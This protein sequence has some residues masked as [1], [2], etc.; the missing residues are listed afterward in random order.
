MQFLSNSRYLYVS[1]ILEV[2]K[3]NL[4]SIWKNNFVTIVKIILK[5]KTPEEG[6][7]Y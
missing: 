5:E 3:N 1:F 6:V 2:D 4:K 7:S